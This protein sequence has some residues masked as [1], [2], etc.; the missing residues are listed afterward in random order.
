[1]QPGASVPRPA[2]AVIVAALLICAGA[3]WAATAM[4]AGSMGMGGLGMAGAGLF[5]FTWLLMMV[6]MM[7][8][9]VAPMVLAY[10]SV[11]R[12]RGAGYGPT[13]VFVTGYL[14]VWVAIGLVPLAVIQ[15]SNQV[16]VSPALWP[17]LHRAGGVAVIAAGLYQL[18]PLKDAC[19]R[20]CRSP[21]GFV[22]SHDWGGG[23]P[24]ALRAGAEHGVYC[25]GCC[26]ALMLVLAVLGLMN[27]AWMAVIAAVFFIEKNVRF[28]DV[29]PKLVAVACVA[30]GL[31]LLIL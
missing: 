19:L 28:G 26:W 3:A 29:V 7:F 11:S 30:G 24:A 2:A 14:A 20:A 21:L 6:A 15:A 4:Q 16:D 23:P 1:M 10:A 18:T 27:L 22:M 5:L 17:V 13:A 9:S 12:R 31:A 25:V 8:P